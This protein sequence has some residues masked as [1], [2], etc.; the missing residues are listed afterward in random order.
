[1]TGNVS[2]LSSLIALGNWM[3]GLGYAAIVLTFIGGATVSTLVIDSGLRRRVDT[4][5]ALVVLV[6]AVLLATLGGLE[7]ILPPVQGV[8]LMIL[9][10]SFLMGLQNAIVTHIS[11]ARVRTTHVSGMS[12]D[13]G[14]GLARLI[15]I[16][17]G[18]ASDTTR[19]A[20]L[21]KLRL[22]AQ[23]VGCF[24]AGGVVGVFLY[25]A[26]G[27]LC[28]SLPHCPFCLFLHRLSSGDI[29]QFPIPTECPREEFNRSNAWP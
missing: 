21:A 12:T 2:T 23:T 13:I 5:Y 3:H 22:H 28:C 7:L 17:R 24:L 19:P 16:A 29:G 18:H 11:D 25:L 15:A 1:M 10:L 6:E 27:T 9:G 14:I 26:I 20:V 8:P 4:V